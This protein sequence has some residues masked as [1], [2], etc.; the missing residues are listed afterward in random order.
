MGGRTSAGEAVSP[1]A[2]IAAV[3][4]IVAAGTL[5]DGIRWMLARHRTRREHEAWPPH[6]VITTR[7]TIEETF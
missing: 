2:Q 6:R 4:L 5:L 1:K 7:N 3:L